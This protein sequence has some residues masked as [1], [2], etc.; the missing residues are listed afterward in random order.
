MSRQRLAIRKAIEAKGYVIDDSELMWFPLGAHLEMQ[1]QEGGWEITIREPDG[2]YVTEI[3][4]YNASGV[5]EQIDYLK[6]FEEV[7]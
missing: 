7:V 4:D 6:P 1:G 2:E 5:I 3:C